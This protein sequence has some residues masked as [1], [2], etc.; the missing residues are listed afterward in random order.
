MV[1]EQLEA[2]GISDPRVLDAMRAVPRESFLAGSAARDPEEAYRDSAL[3]VGRGQTLSQPFMV[4]RM[5]EAL[6]PAPGDRVLEIG[7]GTGYQTAVLARLCDD[8]WSVE[9]DPLLAAE[10]RDRL[11]ALGLDRVR[12]RIGDGS[13]GWAEGAP[14]DGILVTAAAPELPRALVDQL[15]DGGR[16]VIP[17]GPR[18]GQV[19]VRVTRSGEV[20]ERESLLECRFVPLV[21]E[22]GWT[23]AP[24]PGPAT[25]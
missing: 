12:L 1:R 15:A 18:T 20:L 22:E 13:L 16:L 2:R 3:P 6:D 17:V 11:R 24:P 21:G 19:L 25:A 4:A 9:R 10:A 14:F 23:G 8:V 5:T 7:T